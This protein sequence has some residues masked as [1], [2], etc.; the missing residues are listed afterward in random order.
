MCP[1]SACSEGF[2]SKPVHFSLTY[3]SP[4]LVNTYQLPYAVQHQVDALLAHCVVAPGIVVSC[5]LLSCDQLLWMKEL[6]VGSCPN[7]IYQEMGT[8]RS[9]YLVSRG[10]A[11]LPIR[12]PHDSLLGLHFPYL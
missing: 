4:A 2:E 10:D 12:I 9:Y 11:S 5:I 3:Q 7:L 6:A 1:Y 8:I